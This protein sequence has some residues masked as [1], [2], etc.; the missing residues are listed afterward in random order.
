MRCKA[1]VWT[2]RADW[3][4]LKRMRS[5]GIRKPC[6]AYRTLPPAFTFDIIA[7]QAV[8]TRPFYHAQ[9]CG[10]VHTL[11]GSPRDGGVNRRHLSA[12]AIPA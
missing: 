1:L 3:Y 8:A 5:L 9:I 10:N 2:E 6:G 7:I 11:V 4:P 12:L